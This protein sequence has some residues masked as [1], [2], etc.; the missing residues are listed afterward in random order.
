MTLGQVL[1]KNYSS[2]AI[3]QLLR[4]LEHLING[5]SGI[6]TIYPLAGPPLNTH[7]RLLANEDHQLQL[8]QYVSGAYLLDPFYR[9]AVTQKDDG[10]FTIRDV[11]PAGFKQSV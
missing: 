1:T 9:R 10:V 2:Q 4:G 11:A 6:I 3:A 5:S 7:H 8:A